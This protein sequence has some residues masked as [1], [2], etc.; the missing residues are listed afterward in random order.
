MKERSRKSYHDNSHCSLSTNPMTGSEHT[1]RAVSFPSRNNLRRVDATGFHLADEE[2]EAER[3]SSL[4]RKWPASSSGCTSLRPESCPWRLSHT[5]CICHESWWLPSY[6]VVSLSC[7]QP[8]TT[9]LV[10]SLC[11]PQKKAEILA[12]PSPW[13][14]LG[15]SSQGA[16]L[17]SFPV[18][19]SSPDKPL[20]N[21]GRLP[22]LPQSWAPHTM[23]PL[24]YFSFT[25]LSSPFPLD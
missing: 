2:P 3:E 21:S 11:L 9:L 18:G 17:S 23:S 7:W 25:C 15:S 8:G 1:L 4:L 22:S 13:T 6:Q 5:S 19:T 12:F 14:V 10:S 24:I 20:W 16:I